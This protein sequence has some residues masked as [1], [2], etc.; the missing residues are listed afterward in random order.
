MFKSIAQDY[1][2]AFEKKDINTLRELFDLEVTLRDWD[3]EVNGIENVVKVNSEI[4]KNF[5][6]IQVDVISLYG[7]KMTVIGELII[8]LDD[9]TAIKVVDLIEFTT[10]RKIKSIRAYKG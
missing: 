3:I 1:F 4:F 6:N 2:S 9:A 7:E 8:T 10:L 5:N